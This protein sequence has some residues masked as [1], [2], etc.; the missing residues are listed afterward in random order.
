MASG[1]PLSLVFDCCIK[2]IVPSAIHQDQVPMAFDGWWS[3]NT[4]IVDRAR[5]SHGLDSRRSQSGLQQLVQGAQ[6]GQPPNRAALAD[7]M[8][9][10]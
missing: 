3:F 4:A 10:Y 9:L 8:G 2:T 7:S 1:I 6:H 5:K